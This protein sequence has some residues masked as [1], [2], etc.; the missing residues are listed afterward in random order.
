[1]IKTLRQRCLRTIRHPTAVALAHIGDL[2][3]RQGPRGDK[4]P[5]LLPAH[6]P[7]PRRVRHAA[8][9]SSRPRSGRE[10]P[11]PHRRQDVLQVRRGAGPHPV[12]AGPPGQGTGIPPR[13]HGKPGHR[14]PRLLLQHPL[15]P[16]Y[17][18]AAVR[19]LPPA[20][21]HR[22]PRPPSRLRH[23]HRHHVLEV[24][25]NRLLPSHPGLLPDGHRPFPAARPR[26]GHLPGIGLLRRTHR[27]EAG[28]CRT[29]GSMP[30]VPADPPP[31]GR[32]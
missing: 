17:T 8:D 26:W 25:G 7:S 29:L 3:S 31:P 18:L 1:M 4:R 13:N 14:L 16:R 30:V 21:P 6:G 12:A 27:H 11:G 32:T 24:H 10:R 2:C 28:Q 20:R 5:R 19:D 23:G 9:R 22:E 15:R